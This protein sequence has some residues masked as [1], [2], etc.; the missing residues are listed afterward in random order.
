MDADRFDT[1]TRAVTA[2]GSRRTLTQALAALTLGGALGSVGTADVA[3]KTKKKKACPPCKKRKQGKCKGTK[4]DE[5]ACTGGTCQS[6]SCLAAPSAQPAPTCSDGIKNGAE[7]GVDCG[8][9]CPACANGQTCAART[10][11]ASARC[12]SG[13]C[14]ACVTGDCGPSCLCRNGVCTRT[15]GE[16][17]S[18]CALCPA[19]A[20]CLSSPEAGTFCCPR[21]DAP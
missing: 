5:T 2:T 11:C 14:Q 18:F 1:L 4:P 9:S 15:N 16:V 21:C 17:A 12:A 13:T 6:G 3:A 19:G 8:G 7:T 20:V 10:D